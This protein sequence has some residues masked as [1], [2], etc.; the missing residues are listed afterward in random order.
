MM[1]F[2]ADFDW[3]N[4]SHQNGKQCEAGYLYGFCY[5]QFPDHRTF[6]IILLILSSTVNSNTHKN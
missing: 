5:V 6:H 2:W 3:I 4:T 1:E